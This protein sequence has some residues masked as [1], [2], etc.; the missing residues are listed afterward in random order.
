MAWLEAHLGR[1]AEAE[2]KNGG[3]VW[4]TKDLQHAEFRDVSA[5]E[6]GVYLAGNAK[7]HDVVVMSLESVYS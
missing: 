1:L 4:S 7:P 5:K 2:S 3:C 6:L